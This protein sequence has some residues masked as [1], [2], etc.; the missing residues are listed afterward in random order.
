[1]MRKLAAMA[2][3]IALVTGH[4]PYAKAQDNTNR[5][6]TEKAWAVFVGS[7]PTECWA[8]TTPEQ[9]VNTRGGKPVNVRRGKTALFVTFRPSTGTA[10]EVSFTG[11]YPYADG[12]TVQLF[13]DG[14][15]VSDL[16]TQGEWA[17]SPSPEDDRKIIAAFKR[18]VNAKAIG[19]SKRGTRTE[20][21][22]SLLG[23]TAALNEAARRCGM[24][25]PA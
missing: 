4:A 14:E 21:T 22:F 5:V 20:D 13:V 18:G 24:K 12:A 17:W 15:K 6:T 1:M 23:F 2:L 7:N 10:G 8:T 19:T 25:P 3:G 16:F 9:Q 11:G